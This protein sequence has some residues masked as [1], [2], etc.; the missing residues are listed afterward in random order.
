MSPQAMERTV[1]GGRI[2]RFFRLMARQPPL[3]RIPIRF[4]RATIT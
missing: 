4:A 2:A 3:R 1:S